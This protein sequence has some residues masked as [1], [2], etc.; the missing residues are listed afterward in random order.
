[1][2]N[3]YVFWGKFFCKGSIYVF[4]CLFGCGKGGYLCIGF[5]GCCGVCEDESWW[6]FSWFIFCMF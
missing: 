2:G 5:D 6:V 3:M 4:K 1:M